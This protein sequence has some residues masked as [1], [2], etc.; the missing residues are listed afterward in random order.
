MAAASHGDGADAVAPG[1]RDSL[2]ER[3]RT[4]VE[5]EAVAPVEQC[6]AAALSHD[7]R[8]RGR[9][10]PSVAQARHVYPREVRDPVRVHPDQVGVAQRLGGAR[11]RVGG[12]A[13]GA[14]DP[15]GELLERGVR[16]ARRLAHAAPSARRSSKSSSSAESAR[17]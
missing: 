15:G 6:R 7:V 1:P 10:D 3:H 11:G 17:A 2:V 14:K 12:D 4:D 9:V 8:R 16:H 13:A 5:A